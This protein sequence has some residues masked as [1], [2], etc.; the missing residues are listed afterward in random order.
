M[1]SVTSVRP[2]L[3]Q[4]LYSGLSGVG[5][6]A[7]GLVEGDAERRF[8]HSM[9]FVGVEPLLPSYIEMC[10]NMAIEMRDVRARA[11]R[12]W[13]S[14]SSTY[15]HLRELDPDVILLHGGGG[16]TVPALRFARRHRRKLIL[17]EHTPLPLRG[18]A[19]DAV[20]WITRRRADAVVV[21][22][23]EYLSHFAGH[24]PAR[25]TVELIPNGVNTD[26]FRPRSEPSPPGRFTLGMAARMTPSKRFDILI[27]AFVMLR[28][29][30]PDLDWR[31]RLA[32]D[33][34][35]RQRLEQFAARAEG[36]VEF[37][38]MVAKAALPD[39]FRSLDAYVHA[40]EGE[41]L[42]IALLQAMA[43]GLPIVGSNVPGVKDLLSSDPPVGLIAASQS[44]GAFADA[45]SEIV[46][47]RPRAALM[48]RSARDLCVREFSLASMF[49]RYSA[50]IHRFAEGRGTHMME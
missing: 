6:V 26:Q 18:R 23:P 22:T 19:E 8:A 44:A 31:L 32:G 33:G 13:S 21:L 42:S 43:T 20:S 16:S 10:R 14:W 5:D 12:P 35:D 37:C 48:A 25:A 40:S 3:C 39:W 30:R 28:A 45:V 24:A 34:T 27:E 47:N 36:A 49:D 38:G 17:I 1:P 11:G 46:S 4:L 41:A 29:Q 7:F 50:I 9:L 15:R 2:K